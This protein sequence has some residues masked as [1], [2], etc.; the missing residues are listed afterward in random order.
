MT[1]ASMRHAPLWRPLRIKNFRNLLIADVVSDIGSFMQSVGAAWLLVSLGAGPIYVALTQTATALPFL[2]LA[3]PAGSAGDLVDRRRLIL[4]TEGWMV[5]M[6]IAI[7]A[8]TIT[9]RITPWMLLA[10]T[11][12]LSAGD[13]F[14]TPTWRATLPELV[15][16]SELEAASALNGIEFNL[17]RTVGPALAGLVIAAAG[18]AAAFTANVLGF[19]GVIVVISRWKRPHRKRPE[20]TETLAAATVTAIRY[21]WG[22]PALRAV[23]LRSGTVVFCTSAV[24]ALLPTLAHTVSGTAL[25][26]GVLLGCFGAG[27]ILGAIV[28]QP[29]RDRWSTNT[30]VTAGSAVLGLILIATGA[31]TRL[32]TMGSVLMIGGAMWIVIVALVN[33]LVQSLAPDWIRARVI[34]VFVLVTQ[35][36]TAL[37]TAAWGLAAGR[38]G[39]RA[40]LLW[41]GFGTIAAS[42]LTVFAKLP[43]PPSDVVDMWRHCSRTAPCKP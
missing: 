20:Q 19:F 17:A 18:V 31:L 34:A 12:A 41:A 3:L 13:A 7:A 1:T 2:L 30:V 42:T 32:S 29:V 28:M 23:M 6:A 22:D 21:T 35:G 37:G 15:P 10:L 14:E 27:A 25:G 38:I 16:S 36:S 26:Y 24:F 33:A 39:V 43:N 11:F 9:G 8:L 4:F 40:A 5:T